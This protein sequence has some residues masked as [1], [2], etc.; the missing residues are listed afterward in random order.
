[1]MRLLPRPASTRFTRCLARFGLSALLLAATV[2]PVY[3][4]EQETPPQ[5]DVRQITFNE[6]VRI[7]LEQNVALRQSANNVE[8]QSI[9]VS[10]SRAAFLPD[11]RVNSQASQN[12]GRTPDPDTYEIVSETFESFNTSASTSIN[13]FN[14]FGDVARLRQNRLYL[15]AADTQYERQEQAVVFDVMDR[16]LNLL[17]WQEQVN[18]QE[19][20]LTAQ[21]QT[22][23]QI[24]ELV[25]V[26]VQPISD[27]YQQQAQVASTELAL[28]NAQRDAQLAE[29]ALIQVL[30]LDPFG[31]YAF[32]APSVE[33]L[34]LTEEDYD[35][36]NLLQNAFERRSDLQAQLFS[37]SAAREGLRVA[38]SG[39][40]PSIGLSFG[41]GS[42]WSEIY[43]PLV[44]GNSFFDQLDQRRGGQVGFSL[45]L[46]IFDR[47]QTRNNVQRAQVQ[48]EN[49]E[50]DL[51]ALRQNVALEVRQSYLNYLT[52]EKTLDVTEKQLQAADLALEAAQERYNV[53][54]GTIVELTDAQATQ[55]RAASERVQARYD[56]LFQ[57]RLIDYYLG[58]LDPAQ[59]LFE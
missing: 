14:G 6:A 43:N 40:F 1:M 45:S 29:V 41:Y 2:L 51:Q 54:A 47:F 28:L 30:Q 16:Y 12:Y 33:D 11:L 32:T 23:T 9:S 56:F 13:V 42:G 31:A 46:P 59:P 21:Q 27:Q 4:Q 25:R 20:A 19:E 38:R 3:A 49:A 5:T 10:E 58:V 18:I 8:A 36:G 26:G 15:D 55:V 17:T 34:P 50:L 52:A 39:Y 7:A 53:G 24:E 44:G 22:L 57:K 35:L 48:Y 37:I